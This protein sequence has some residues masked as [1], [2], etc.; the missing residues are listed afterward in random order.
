MINIQSILNI[1]NIL[2]MADHMI[3]FIYVLLIKLNAII[4]VIFYSN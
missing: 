3:L 2:L 4:L 1:D